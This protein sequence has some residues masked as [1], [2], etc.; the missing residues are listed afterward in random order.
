MIATESSPE[1]R[2]VSNRR[3]GRFNKEEVLRDLWHCLVSRQVSANTRRE[4]LSGKAK[5]G[6]GSAG[7]ELLQA[8]MAK[9]FAKGDFF[10][11]YY[12][13]QTFMLIKGIATVEQLFAAVYADSKNDPFSGGRQMNNHFSTPLIDE[14]GNWTAHTSSYN[15]A[16]ALA[17]LAGQVPHALGIA[18][19]SKLYRQNEGLHHAGSFSN[20]GNEVSFCTLGDA[21][22]SEGVFFEAV[23]AA[24]VMK[25]PIAF[26]IQDDGYGIS[27]PTEYQTTKGSISE[28]LEGF[29]LNE[30]GEGLNIHTAKAW[31]YEGLCRTFRKGIAKIRKTHIP[32]IFHIQECTQPFGH[33]TSG[34]HQRYKSKD[35]LQWEKDMD[36]LMAF[37]EWIVLNKIASQDELEALK[38]KALQEE[39]TGRL[40]AWENYQGPVRQARRELTAILDQLVTEDIALETVKTGLATLQSLSNPTLSE[41]LK[42]A[43]YLFM[44]LG[45]REQT[46]G[47]TALKNWRA[48]QRRTLDQHYDTHLYSDTPKSALK[49]PVVPPVYDENTESI[50]GYQL[51]NRF[52]DQALEKYPELCAFGEDVGKIGDVNQA[53]ANMQKKYGEHRVF[54][55]GIR[56]WTIAGQAIGM[57]MRGLRPIAEIQYLD[58]LAYA[59][60]ALTDDL[61]TL[62]YRTNGQ[63]AAPAIIRTRGHRLEGIWHSG[64]P[65][66][67]LINSMRGIYILTPRNM[68]QAAGMYNTMLQSDDPAIIIECLNG[69][70]NKEL[71]PQNLDTFTV[72]LGVPEV[73]RAGTDVTLVTYGSC[74][75]I[76]GEAAELLARKGI[77]VELIDVQTLLPFDLEERILHSLKKTNRIVFLDEDVPGGA[78]AFMLQQVL[79]K[80]GGYRYLDSTPLTITGKAQRPPYG[81]D[82]DYFA[83]PYPIDVYENIW[84][85]MVEAEPGRFA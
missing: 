68:A 45:H 64:S 10:S 26:I 83:K 48:Q 28:V 35:R 67:M 54:D 11:G 30:L 36:C 65:L 7:K 8:A 78:T 53:F 63:Q 58:Y 51:L 6:M 13:D 41:L 42:E 24:G 72:P 43:D 49:V 84:N 52:F 56:E 74:V 50:N 55:T 44:T 66:G 2:P 61:A 15:V 37:E 77:S 82:G 22:T 38:K 33:S 3:S 17:P 25:V 29:R 14:A 31:D 85:M 80:Q 81:D 12:R 9:T 70:R 23:N 32:A 27:V 47:L 20:K 57:A 62:R 60:P 73:L 76:A 59:F 1:A 46:E 71:A 75:R 19:A 40:R 34:S 4:V 18:L 21:T 69:Y 16:S 39:K 79:E 5:F